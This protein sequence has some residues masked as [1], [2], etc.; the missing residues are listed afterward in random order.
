[1][2][3]LGLSETRA[4]GRRNIMNHA[5][6]PPELAQQY[7]IAKAKSSHRNK[8]DPGEYPARIEHANVL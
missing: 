6:P 5:T 4:D 2:T 3:S 7:G 1:M 8:S